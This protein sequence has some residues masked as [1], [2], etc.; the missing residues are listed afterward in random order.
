MRVWPWA[1][2]WAK[3]SASI[4]AIGQ[5]GADWR[6]C[7]CG[8]MW[9][10]CCE[11]LCRAKDARCAT[12][13]SATAARRSSLSARNPLAQCL[14]SQGVDALALGLRRDRQLLVQFGRDSE[15]ELAGKMAAGLDVL[16]RA[17]RKEH[18]K[19]L[20]ERSEEHTSELQSLMR[21][22]Y[23]VFCLKKK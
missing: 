16:F 3:V 6:V 14:L 19:R 23:A 2:S 20:L 22:S 15:I 13:T 1:A 10:G 9:Q 18:R 11:S 12:P 17:H 8:G 21:I 7:Q 5:S 4:T